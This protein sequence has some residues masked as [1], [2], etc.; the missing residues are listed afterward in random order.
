MSKHTPGPWFS[1]PGH[2]H[3]GFIDIQSGIEVVAQVT[4]SDN[5][6]TDQD[7]ANANLIAAAPKMLD[8][9]KTA[10]SHISDDAL[11]AW[12]GSVICEAEGI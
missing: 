12:V 10:H 1:L 8:A 6:P 2:S 7:L 4:Q 5:V 3:I 9:L 11:R